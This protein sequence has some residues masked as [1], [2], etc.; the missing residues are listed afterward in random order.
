MD[1]T[2][3]LVPEYRGTCNPGYVDPWRGR[4]GCASLGRILHVTELC[5]NIR[6]L[7]GDPWESNGSGRLQCRLSGRGHYLKFHSSITTQGTDTW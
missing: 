5:R 2:E 7:W 6:G 1:P 4:A 3:F